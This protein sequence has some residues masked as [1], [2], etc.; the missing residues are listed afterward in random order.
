MHVTDDFSIKN[1]LAESMEHLS[2]EQFKIM[3]TQAKSNILILSPKFK[4]RLFIW[5]SLDYAIQCSQTRSSKP[6]E[7]WN[8][9]ILIFNVEATCHVIQT[10]NQAD[11]NSNVQRHQTLNNCILLFNYTFTALI[12]PHQHE[13]CKTEACRIAKQPLRL[14]SAASFWPL[15][16]AVSNARFIAPL[17]LPFV[18]CPS[19]LQSCGRCLHPCT[20]EPHRP[21][22]TYYSIYRLARKSSRRQQSDHHFDIDT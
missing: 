7:T 17:M 13:T 19:H 2:K 21:T 14:L 12:Q 9:R 4:Y 5:V 18:N 8:F 6:P 11:Q 22:A 16:H 20:L 1:N 10:H 3:V 15:F